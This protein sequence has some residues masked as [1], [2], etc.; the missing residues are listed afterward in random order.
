LCR[1][2][3]IPLCVFSIL[4]RGGLA[5]ILSGE[6]RGTTIGFAGDGQP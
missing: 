2:N 3:R 6:P 4:E 1:D 5:A